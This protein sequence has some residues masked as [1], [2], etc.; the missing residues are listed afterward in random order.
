[1]RI[2]S[3]VLGQKFQCDEPMELEVFGFVDNADTT[4][5]KFSGDAMVRMV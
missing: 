2:V 3:E 5:A 1:L 4:A